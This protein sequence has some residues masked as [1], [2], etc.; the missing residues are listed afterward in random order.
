MSHQTVAYVYKDAHG[1]WR[2]T[3]S[4]VSLDSV[5]YAYW[6]GLSPEA[7][8]EEFPS[9]GAE[10]VYGAIAFYLQNKTEIDRYLEQQAQQW[11]ALEQSSAAQHQPLLDR[12]RTARRSQA[13]DASAS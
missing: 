2:I 1:S 4:R 7:I 11:M 8:A 10:Y 12:I 9:L 5:V 6:D 3:G 13:A